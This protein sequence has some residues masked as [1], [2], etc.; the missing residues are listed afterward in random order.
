MLIL[1]KKK[2]IN[3]INKDKEEF[4]LLYYQ[5]IQKNHDIYTNNKFYLDIFGD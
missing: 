1:Q 2:F 4:I 3:F 5:I